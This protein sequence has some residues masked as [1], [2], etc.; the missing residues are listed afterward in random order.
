M[1][2]TLRALFLSDP[3]VVVITIVM[4][5]IDMIASLM[6]SSGHLQHR[7]A[8]IWSRMLL[9]GSG[10]KVRVSGLEKIEP[11]GSY[12]IASNHLSLF[13]TPVVL[14]H[15]P[16][17]FRFMAK[18]GL[19]RVPFIG[20]HLRRGGHIRVPR[21]NPR[22]AVRAIQ[23]AGRL[24]RERHVSILVFPEGGRSHGVLQRFKEG[25]AMIAIAGGVPVVPVA[26]LGT[27]RVLPMGSAI[28]RSGDVELRIGD[29]IPTTGLTTKDRGRLTERVREEV[30]GLIEGR[31]NA[32][33]DVS[34]G[35]LPRGGGHG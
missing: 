33:E 30:A 5:T 35:R 19:F 34:A 9:A 22:A 29:P 11:G 13:D 28:V 31:Q 3:L 6:D 8:R 27:H 24:L 14:G 15:V 20:Y 4:G 10:V 25:A 2:R 1:L 12:I 26:I 7:V 23:E 17:Q 32:E 16:V 21:E 18:S